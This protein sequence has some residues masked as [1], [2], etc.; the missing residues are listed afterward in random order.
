MS[1]LDT[2]LLAIGKEASPH[3]QVATDDQLML[4][5]PV[6]ERPL[7]RNKNQAQQTVRVKTVDVLD[8]HGRPW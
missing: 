3:T 5:L 4:V 8:M 2:P 6:T 1:T 7:S